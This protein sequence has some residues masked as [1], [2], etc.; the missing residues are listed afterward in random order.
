MRRLGSLLAGMGLAV[1]GKQKTGEILKSFIQIKI[2]SGA[3]INMTTNSTIRK[4]YTLNFFEPGANSNKVWKGLAYEDGTFETRFGRVRDG[5]N[6]MS[7]VKR[8][9]SGAA[10]ESMLESKRKEKLRKGYRDALVLDNQMTVATAKPQDLSIIAAAQIAGAEDSTTAELIKYLAEVNIH[11]ITHATSIR[12]NAASGTFTTPLGILTPAAIKQARRLLGDIQS[13]NSSSFKTGYA[14]Q[15]SGLVR[16][17]FQL[18]PKDFGMRVPP[19]DELLKEHKQIVE[20][21]SILD[22]LEAALTTA[23]PVTEAE[24]VFECKLSKLPHWTEE[25]KNLFRKIRALYDSTKNASHQTHGLK[26]VRVYEVEI[27]TMKSAFEKTAQTLGNVRQDLWHGTRAS[28]L[29]SILKSGLVIPPASSAHCTG[30][31]FGN[32]IYSSLQSTKALNY[33]TDFWNRSGGKGQRT[34]MFLCEAALGKTHKPK[35]SGS[36]F[37]AKGTDSTWVE[38]G[39]AGVMNHEAIVYNAAQIN[40]KFLCEFGAV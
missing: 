14:P 22:A 31:M 15:R 40:L 29:L 3:N 9:S 17:Y 25:G 37:P 24:K 16:D 38:A 7:S 10:A 30:R 20:Q 8:L 5:A 26:L 13:V 32:G 35:S 27:P 11:S 19:S 12:Y 2:I 18:V 36:N 33:A 39:T 4:Q 34:F 23:A 1:L 21:N 6:L 28:N